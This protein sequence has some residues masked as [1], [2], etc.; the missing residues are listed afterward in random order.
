[1]Q[2]AQ[3]L[4]WRGQESEG[5]QG[6]NLQG[7]VWKLE[8]GRGWD[9]CFIFSLNKQC[10]QLYHRS[11]L[12]SKGWWYHSKI[13]RSLPSRF[14]PK[15]STLEELSYMDKLSMDMLHGT[16]T[17]YELRTTKYKSR[18]KEATFKV[19]KEGTKCKI[20]EDLSHESNE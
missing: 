8:K 16:L 20:K 9:Y 1:M 5:N 13:L 17:A 19:A 15:V 12:R 2:Q 6:T 4:L 14:N 10:C 3:K 18:I 11:Q 7:L